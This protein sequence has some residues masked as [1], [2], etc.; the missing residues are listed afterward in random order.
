MML[1]LS[2]C[3]ITQTVLKQASCVSYL[4]GH[5]DKTFER[6]HLS[7]ESFI[8]AQK[9]KEITPHCGEGMAAKAAGWVWGSNLPT[10]WQIL[11]QRA[12]Q[13]AELITPWKT[14]FHPYICQASPMSKSSTTTQNNTANLESSVQETGA[15]EVISHSKFISIHHDRCYFKEFWL[16]RKMLPRD[17]PIAYIQHHSFSSKKWY[18][19][20]TLLFASNVLHASLPG[21]YSHSCYHMHKWKYFCSA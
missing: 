20:L 16:C 19:Y 15:W 17:T 14:P 7:K 10:S 3:I 8:L 18:T 13:E 1:Y 9:S 4:S 6:S 11:K 5:H 21:C 2:G 12:R